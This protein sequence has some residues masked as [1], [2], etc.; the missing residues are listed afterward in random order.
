MAKRVPHLGEVRVKS[1]S[2]D[3]SVASFWQA[4]GVVALVTLVAMHEIVGHPF[5][6]WDD[7]FNF[8]QNARFNPVSLESIGYFWSHAFAHLYIPVT[9]TVWGVLAFIAGDTSGGHAQL[10]PHVFHAA[11]VVC[12]IGAA[13]GA[14]LVLRRL[15]MRTWSAAFGA[16]LFAVHPLQVESVAWASGLKDVLSG[17]LCFWAMWFLGGGRLGC[18]EGKRGWAGYL[19]ATVSFVL[20]MLCKPQAVCLPVV[21]IA[22]ELIRRPGAWKQWG[23]QLLLWLVLVVPI[24][25]VGKQNQPAVE[26]GAA[27]PMQDRP[28]VALDDLV[29]YGGKV[30]APM[31]LAVDYNRNTEW[32]LRHG[33][34]IAAWVVP[35]VVL[36]LAW[37]LRRRARWLALGLAIFV[38]ALI[39]I[40]GLVPFNYQMYSN[41]ADHYVHFAMLGPALIGAALLQAGLE[42]PQSKLFA[43]ILAG[44]IVAVLVIASYREADYWRDKFALYDRN[45]QLY[46]ESYAA[47]DQMGTYY[48]SKKDYDKA[49]ELYNRAPVDAAGR[50]RDAV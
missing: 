50:L 41:V 43:G 13:I 3:G 2:G 44:I 47:T 14:L 11:S 30:I 28:L 40:L 46:P 32:L 10:D 49:L 1:E 7:Q 22:V 37:M 24:I 12:H 15:G 34:H 16:L 35:P 42:H 20:A 38:G 31:D 39:P 48:A 8:Y 5:V 9:Y 25:L 36:V 26:R 17:G 33:P 29:F 18:G 23:W 19:V 21:L 45:L 6:D 27:T 4:A